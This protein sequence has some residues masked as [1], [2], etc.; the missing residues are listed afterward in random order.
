MNEDDLLRLIETQTVER[1][2]SLAERREGLEALD[3]MINADV[4]RGVVLFGVR[5]TGEVVGIEEGNADTAQRSLADHIRHKFSPQIT[6]EIQVVERPGRPVLVISGTRDPSVPLVE[7]DGRA[8]IREGPS[9]RQLTLP[10]KL[11]IIRR[12]DRSQ[13][14]G[15]WRC[16]RCGSW[17]GHLVSYE[18]SDGG[19]KANY[20]C[21]C[22]G[23]YWPAT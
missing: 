14:P 5:P 11:Q 15:P 21:G 18:L 10:Q 3:A 4:G 23:E 7:Y 8:F 17:V 2:S 13:H 6:F 20:S 19:L 9:Q 16:D 22:G 1:K 12:R